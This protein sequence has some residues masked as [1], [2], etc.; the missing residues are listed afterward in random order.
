[1]AKRT[2]VA[3]SGMNKEKSYF[4][5]RK[6]LV[7][8]YQER[9]TSTV[10]IPSDKVVYSTSSKTSN[11]ELTYRDGAWWAFALHTKGVTPAKYKLV[12][13]A[14]QKAEK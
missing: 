6:N 2:L 4:T 5:D 7:F 3:V 12:V 13:I 11:I 8:A 1:M 10:T 14:A 9:G